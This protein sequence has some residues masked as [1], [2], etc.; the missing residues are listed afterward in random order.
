MVT[1]H[2]GLTLAVKE[3]SELVPGE[4]ASALPESL[5]CRGDWDSVSYGQSDWAPGRYVLVFWIKVA[6]KKRR[7]CLSFPLKGYI[8]MFQIQV[9]EKKKKKKRAFTLTLL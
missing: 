5:C 4:S 1:S 9:T 8:Y 2:K 6:E 3:L 7:F